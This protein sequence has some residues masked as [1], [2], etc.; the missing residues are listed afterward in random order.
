MPTANKNKKEI[1]HVASGNIG[2]VP[3]IVLFAANAMAAERGAPVALWCLLAFLFLTDGITLF[4]LTG[5]NVRYDQL[6]ADCA[7]ELGERN[8]LLRTAAAEA[9]ETDRTVEACHNSTRRAGVIGSSWL[10][11]AVEASRHTQAKAQLLGLLSAVMVEAPMRSMPGA[12]LRLY[13]VKGATEEPIEALDSVNGI[14]A[15]REN[16]RLSTFP[17]NATIESG[18]GLPLVAD[19]AIPGAVAPGA[20]G[21]ERTVKFASMVAQLDGTCQHALF[22]ELGSGAQL[23]PSS[24]HLMRNS[25]SRADSFWGAWS[26]IRFSHGV[27]GLLMPCSH[28]AALGDFLLSAR[29]AA[30]LPTLLDV[31][32][33]KDTEKFGALK[34]E[35]LINRLAHGTSLIARHGLI[36]FNN[37]EHCGAAF[38]IEGALT[39]HKAFD[40]KACAHTDLSPCL[41]DLG[42]PWLRYEGG[43]TARDVAAPKG[44]QAE[45]KG[46]SARLR[47]AALG[48]HQFIVGSER[49]QNCEKTC[50]EEGLACLGISSEYDKVNNCDALKLAFGGL[51]KTCENS[52][53]D[54]QPALDVDAGACLVKTDHSVFRC[55]ASHPKTRRLCVC[56]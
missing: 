36:M 34:T 5:L 10:T 14:A 30:G 29:R 54:E 15:W 37:K 23:C 39:D 55:K 42:E 4:A 48:S 43:G 27:N 18:N 52:E 51:C 49:G 13:N 32:F 25:V 8:L 7:A 22:L 53:G 28:L 38:Q 56:Q 46:K 41:G 47:H 9:A 26:A 12:E 33:S 50:E 16:G 44:A 19:N 35:Y 20:D 24:L 17:P 40:G 31:W 21:E 1:G 11:I 3:F 2:H 45:G 6:Q